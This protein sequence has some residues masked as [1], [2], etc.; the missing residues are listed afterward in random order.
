MAYRL[1][2]GLD[3]I[4]GPVTGSDPGNKVKALH[5]SSQEV[6]V[7]EAD[8]LVVSPQVGIG[9]GCLLLVAGGRWHDKMADHCATITCKLSAAV[10]GWSHVRDSE[11]E[12]TI[13]TV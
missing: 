5:Q 9:N 10:A 2:G 11:M 1:Q 6:P 3:E 7:A 4:I 13:S 8:T 12:V